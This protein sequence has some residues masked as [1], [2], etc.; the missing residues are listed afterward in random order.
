MQ[1]LSSTPFGR[2]PV[3]AGHL[4]RQALAARPAPGLRADKWRLLNLLKAT[5]RVHGLSDRSLTVLS[6]LLSFHPERELDADQPLVVWPSNA[7][8]CERANGMPESSLRRHLTALIEAGFLLRHDSPNGKRYARRARHSEGFVA[9]GFS[10]RP[11]VLA[12]AEL[13]AAEIAEEART[14]A[15]SAARE[16][17]ALVLRDIAKFQDF[18]GQAPCPG[19]L[20][21]RK[22]LRRKLDAEALAQLLRAALTLRETVEKSLPT[23]KQTEKMSGNDSQNERHIQNSNPKQFEFEPSETVK[24]ERMNLLQVIETCPDILPYARHGLRSWTD[25]EEA[26][27]FASPML[28]IDQSVWLEAQ[29]AMGKTFAAMTVAAI[30][31][32]VEVIRSPGA[33]LRSLSARAA[34]KKFTPIPMLQALVRVA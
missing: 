33:Y 20:D 10:L 27:D 21:L 24:T 34:R 17:V 3:T 8:L 28:G 6:A 29:R 7:A 31:Q 4:E 22:S 2:R 23:L 11:L 5:R 12:V 16:E 26:A 13:E 15:L 32:R 18:L 1:Q 9:F 14:E 30:L 25:L 19:L